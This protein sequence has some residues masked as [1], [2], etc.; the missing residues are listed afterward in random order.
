MNVYGE[1]VAPTGEKAT[2]PV[3][4][5]RYKYQALFRTSR[6]EPIYSIAYVT[7]RG[8]PTSTQSTD[9]DPGDTLQND[10]TLFVPRGRYDLLTVEINGVYVKSLDQKVRNPHRSVA[11]GLGKDLGRQRGGC[12]DLRHEPAHVAEPL[13]TG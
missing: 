11:V 8:D 7:R 5:T 4:D 12:H 13:S 6:P 2:P 3:P 10:Y 9:L 1:R